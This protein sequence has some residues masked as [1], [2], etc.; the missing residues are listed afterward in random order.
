MAK[1]ILILGAGKSSITLIKY[2]SNLSKKI[3]IKIYV[4]ALDISYY[5][6]NHFNNVF[7]ITFDINENT[8][9]IALIKDSF[10]VVSMLPA[11]LHYRI[12]KT[13]SFIGKNIIT[14]SY[15]TPEIKKLESQFIKNDSFLLM[16]MGLDPGIDHMSAMNIIDKLK[17]EHEIKS[18]ESYT[19]GL[20]TPNNLNNPWKYKFTWNSRNVILAGK[21]GAK[22]LK[23]NKKI[24]LP[25]SEIFNKINLINIPK[26]GTYEA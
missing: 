6:N 19:G 14:A 13:C 16:E 24:N 23:N 25:Y 18:F 12:A 4:A 11:F 8:K 1:N 5:E 9:L 7:P 17:K 26:L 22:Y 3:E 10:I 15:L 2:L 21:E 20:L